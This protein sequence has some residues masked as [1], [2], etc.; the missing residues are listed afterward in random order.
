M[1]L[2]SKFY[3][4]KRLCIATKHA[5]ERVIAPIL[6]T[7][8]GV[9]CEVVEGLDTDLLGTFSGEIERTL[10]PLEAAKEK[11]RRAGELSSCDLIVANEG[12]F[13]PHPSFFFAPAG[14]EI[15][16]LWDRSMDHFVVVRHLTT[17]T[18]FG[19][20]DCTNFRQLK[21]FALSIGFP[22][23]GLMLKSTSN[24]GLKITKDLNHLADL[25]TA[26]EEHLKQHGKCSVE[27]DMRAMRNPTRMKSLEILTQKLVSTANSLCPKC[28][29][30]GFSVT[31]SKPGLPCS[32]CLQPTENVLIHLLSCTKCHFTEELWYPHEVKNADPMHCNHCNP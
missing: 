10:S 14:D 30:P 17:E 4:G 6:Q 5:K 26:F 31:G 2:N 32:L 21:D 12:S 28:Q 29:T 11:C 18:N 22:E 19:G 16:V 13:G 7:A 15:M 3:E 1:V 20:I 8:L 27:T 24:D 25:E 23:H 9:K